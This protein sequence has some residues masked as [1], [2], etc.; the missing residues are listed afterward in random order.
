MVTVHQG[1][2]IFRTADHS[3]VFGRDWNTNIKTQNAFLFIFIFCNVDFVFWCQKN[4]E[5]PS[6]N[7]NFFF[8]K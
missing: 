8:P 2:V 5:V 7:E 4:S 6:R 3:F 1:A